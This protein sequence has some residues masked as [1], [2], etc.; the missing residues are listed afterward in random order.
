MPVKR[1]KE[2]NGFVVGT[3]LDMPACC[4]YLEGIA[5]SR[6]GHPTL[7]VISGDGQ[8]HEVLMHPQAI[9]VRAATLEH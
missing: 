4:G 3:V 2:W 6:E 1:P 8:R 9:N 5:I 7:T